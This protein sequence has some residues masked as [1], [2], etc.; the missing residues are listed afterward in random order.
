MKMEAQEPTYPALGERSEGV[1]ET[2]HVHQVE[3]RRPSLQR[4]HGEVKQ[5]SDEGMLHPWEPQWQEFLDSP[6]P[7]WGTPPLEPTPWDDAKAFLASFEQ[8]AEACR[9]PR[10]EWVAHLLPALSGEAEQAFERMEARDRVEYGKVKAAILQGDTINR[11]K[12]RQHFRRFCYQEA[13][14]PRG[15]YSRLQELCHGWL[16]ADRHSK[17]QILELLIL[18]QFL[19]ILPSEI[20]TW[21]RGHSPETCSQAVALAE[22]F[23]LRQQEAQRQENQA[24]TPLAMPL[25]EA[26]R[27]PCDLEKRRL[28]REAKQESKDGSACSR[29]QDLRSFFTGTCQAVES[30]YADMGPKKAAPAE[31]GKR[32]KEKITLEMKKEI[33][34]KHD[35]GM[36]LTDLAREYGRNPSTIGT[37]LKM[38]EKILATDVAKGVTRIVKNRPAVLE[39]VEKLLLIWMEEKQ[40]AGDRV[41]EAVICEKAKALHAD[42]I[43]Q[44]PGTSAEP[45]VFKASRGWFERFK[46]RS[47]IH[48]VVRHG[49]AALQQVFR[50]A[51][52]STVLE[53]IVSLGRTM[54]LEVTEEDVCE[55]VED[56]DQELFTQELVRLQTE[57]TQEQASL[58]EEEATSEEQLSSTELKDICQQ[59]KN[60]QTYAQRHHPD[61]ALARELAN[62]FDTRIMS[63]FRGVLKRRLKQQTMERFIMKKQRV[64]EEPAA[65]T[66]GAQLPSSSSSSS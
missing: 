59:W 61:K 1:E 60:V 16:K 31:A 2:S 29:D 8:V 49:E 62:M 58:E 9:W 17:E 35:R 25:S 47:G 3:T 34:R 21:V 50:I 30:N 41:T 45:E 5:E 40:R 28:Q 15:A 38:R 19:A 10:E 52:E 44:E 14:G 18:E 33:I 57:A 37:I 42:L 32:T 7:G 24:V 53:D 22:D 63:S 46:T 12:L 23:L 27:A 13:E 11:E 55:L 20:L 43:Q 65:S 36:R 48:S 51:P 56:H 39:E 4:I 54:G 66:S 64:E 26:E 6:H